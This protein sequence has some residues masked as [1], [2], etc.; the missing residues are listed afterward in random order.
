MGSRAKEGLSFEI[1][2]LPTRESFL[3]EMFPRL[4]NQ[5]T[6][7]KSEKEETYSYEDRNP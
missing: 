5:E 2:N 7:T 1:S 4:F 3:R 6:P